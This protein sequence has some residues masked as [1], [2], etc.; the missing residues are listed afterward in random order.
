MTPDRIIGSKLEGT[1]SLALQHRSSTGT[2]CACDCDSFFPRTYGIPE[3][4]RSIRPTSFEQPLPSP[5][6]TFG[7][8][9]F[10]FERR[11]T[12][13]S[14]WGYSQHLLYAHHSRVLLPT[15]LFGQPRSSPVLPLTSFSEFVF[16]CPMKA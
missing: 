14:F 11:R 5:I 12:S 13:S 10:S 8:R 15:V 2:C 9:Q 16:S 3:V 7:L 1:C 6:S 4:L